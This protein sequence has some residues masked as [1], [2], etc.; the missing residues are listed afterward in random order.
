MKYYM[1]R[2][3]VNRKQSTNNNANLTIDFLAG[4][5]A[6]LADKLKEV[7]ATEVEVIKADN[8][9]NYYL[10]VFEKTKEKLQQKT[11]TNITVV[12]PNEDYIEYSFISGLLK[13]AHIENPKIT[14]KVVGIDHLSIQHV[15]TIKNI[16]ETEQNTTDTEVRYTNGKREIKN[17]GFTGICVEIVS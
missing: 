7:L 5:S 3:F 4:G 17:L 12:Y 13:T 15:E 2:K 8:E 1:A 14:G 9:E 11:P 10:E 6:D 16:I